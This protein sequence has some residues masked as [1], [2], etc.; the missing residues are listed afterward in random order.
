MLRALSTEGDSNGSSSLGGH[1]HHHRHA[2]GSNGAGHHPHAHAHGGASSELFAARNLLAAGAA[3]TAG[4]V[5][6]KSRF[7]QKP[8]WPKAVLAKSHFGQ[9]PFWPKAFLARAVAARIQLL[10]PF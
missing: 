3:P 6:A 5:L 7:G 9:K 2:N 8:F 1:H 4:A 10:E